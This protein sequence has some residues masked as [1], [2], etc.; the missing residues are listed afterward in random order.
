M[1]AAPD[2]AVQILHTPERD[3]CGPAVKAESL[4]GGATALLRSRRAG[5]TTAGR[6]FMSP[7]SDRNRLTVAES[8][9]SVNC[10]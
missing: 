6:F 3:S 8:S 2:E 7:P 9:R 1:D 4:C 10:S 5:S